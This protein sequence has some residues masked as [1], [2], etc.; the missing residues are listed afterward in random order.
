MSRQAQDTPLTGYLAKLRLRAGQ[1][2]LRA[3]AASCAVSHTTIGELLN[4][5]IMPRWAAVAAV[6]EALGA[7][8]D[9]LV[10]LSQLWQF[11]NR[12]PKVDQLAVLATRMQA[13]E[14][15]LAELIEIQT[16][17]CTQRHEEPR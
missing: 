4:G 3:I 15:R 9:E 2:S 11:Q 8:E 17:V 13:L 10:E 7:T 6:G 1:P 5:K 16:T 12:E 14:E